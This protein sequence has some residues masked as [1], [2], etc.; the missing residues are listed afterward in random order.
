MTREEAIEFVKEAFIA[1]ES[2]YRVPHEDWTETHKARGMAI[3]ALS[4]E[5]AGEWK[6]A[7]IEKLESLMKDMENEIE[8]AK[9]HPE[10]YTKNFIIGMKE[11]VAGVA[12]A[13]HEIIDMPSAEPVHGEWI[14]VSEGLPSES[15]Q[16]LVFYEGTVIGSWIEIMW[17]GKPL[18]PNV[19]VGGKHFYLS[20]SECGDIIYD[21]VI[22]WMPLPEPYKGGDD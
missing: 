18:M 3:E 2:E 9:K 5:G 20:D 12:H 8:D 19:D 1:W 15:G 17:Y 22:A 11:Q 10:N 13:A 6:K 4:A 7:V 21:E 16:Y 14:P